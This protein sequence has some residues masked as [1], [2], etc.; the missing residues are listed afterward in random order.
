MSNFI[1]D[2][3]SF[4]I[5]EEEFKKLNDMNSYQRK[6]WL[7]DKVLEGICNVDQIQE[8]EEKFDNR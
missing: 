1:V 5:D 7:A 4:S 3:E 8:D 2:V 6:I